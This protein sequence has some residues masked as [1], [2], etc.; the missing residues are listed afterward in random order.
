[1]RPR[2]VA[3]ACAE[4]R[5]EV[6]RAGDSPLSP[7]R[8]S[9]RVCSPGGGLGGACLLAGARRSVRAAD[10]GRGRAGSGLS[11]GPQPRASCATPTRPGASLRRDRRASPGAGSGPSPPSTGTMFGPWRPTRWWPGGRPP[12]PDRRVPEAVFQT[13]G[14]APVRHEERGCPRV[15][16]RRL[17]RH[18]R[19]RHRPAATRATFWAIACRS[20][21]RCAADEVPVGGGSAEAH[22]APV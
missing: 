1:M 7:W 11:A 10:R 2:A 18:P 4:V 14:R 6:R 12:R 9:W 22:P 20:S 15:G 5:D 3:R 13:G 8:P 21:T 16:L 19:A 17:R